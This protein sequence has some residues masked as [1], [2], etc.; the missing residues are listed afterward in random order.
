MS[1]QRLEIALRESMAEGVK[2]FAVLG[3]HSLKIRLPFQFH[4]LQQAAE[5][6][7]GLE[8]HLLRGS[9]VM[10]ILQVRGEVELAFLVC[11]RVR[12]ECLEVLGIES[13]TQFRERAA[14]RV[15]LQERFVLLRVALLIVL[16]MLEIGGRVFRAVELHGVRMRDRVV[17]R[18]GKEASLQEEIREL[19]GRVL[20]GKRREEL[21]VTRP[22]A[23]FQR[24]E[25]HVGGFPEFADDRGERFLGVILGVQVLQVN[26]QSFGGSIGRFG[27]EHVGDIAKPVGQHELCRI[28][29]DWT[30]RRLVCG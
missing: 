1:Q 21:G 19:T 20:I 4:H 26:D 9:D 14:E 6:W 8:A 13:V 2:Q 24:D 7:I 27:I 17:D 12:D 3:V 22:G 10:K 23:P 16:Q 25:R 11:G 18:T 28:D 15:E 5:I 29:G 30:L